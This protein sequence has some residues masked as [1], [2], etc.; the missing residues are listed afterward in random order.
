M[1]VVGMS[2]VGAKVC[3]NIILGGVNSLTMLDSN[4]V[5]ESDFSSNFF[6][7]RDSIG[8]NVL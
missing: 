2:G 7:N 3:K 5:Q 6:L 4:S 8:Q 1:L